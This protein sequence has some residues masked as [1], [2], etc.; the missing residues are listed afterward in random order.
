MPRF[1]YPRNAVTRVLQQQFQCD[2]G[3]EH[4]DNGGDRFLV[5]S[6]P[7]PA[8]VA[9][10]YVDQYEVFWSDL[11]ALVSQ[12]GINAQALSAALDREPEYTDDELRDMGD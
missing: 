9:I 5:I 2:I 8:Q 4:G 11:T 1:T 10:L 7:G 3:E 6:R 12:I